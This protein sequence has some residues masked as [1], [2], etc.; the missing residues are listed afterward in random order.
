MLSHFA[1][2]VMAV[3]QDTRSSSM[4]S[5]SIHGPSVANTAVDVLGHTPLAHSCTWASV[6]LVVLRARDSEQTQ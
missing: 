2:Q 1:K 4:L 6:H 3:Q 5:C